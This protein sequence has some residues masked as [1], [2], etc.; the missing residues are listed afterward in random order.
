MFNYD[1]S[2]LTKN[3]APL[4]NKE[5]FLCFYGIFE[6]EK[7]PFLSFLLFKY[8]S[9]DLMSFIKIKLSDNIE[10]S[11]N[12]FSLRTMSIECNI[13]GYK[14]YDTHHYVFCFLD[15]PYMLQNEHSKK[16]QLWWATIDEICNQHRVLTFDI[17]HSV[18]GI[19]FQ[20][21]SLIYLLDEDKK[22]LV[23]PRIGYYGCNY[24]LM[25]YVSALGIQQSEYTPFGNFYYFNSYTRAFKY[26]GWDYNPGKY[27]NVDEHNRV[28]EGGIVRF[29]VFLKNNRMF[30]NHPQDPKHS[31]N[32]NK[33]EQ[34]EEI[35]KKYPRL[36]DVNGEWA[37]LNDSL[38]VGVMVDKNYKERFHKFVREQYIL[39]KFNDYVALSSHK[40]DKK[41]LG[42]EWKENG[43]YD[44]K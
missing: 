7:N 34:Y 8:P 42:I 9:T 31:F 43:E 27:I 28:E 22:P 37:K 5:V 2:T 24:K 4:K 21:P 39:K 25:S 3:T 6:R 19:F 38:Y 26:A 17:H 36:I 12:E 15:F 20:N 33:S 40:I 41:T 23:I 16:S 1:L 44:I 35:Y 32:K 30:L 13:M 11:I 18:Y 29:A 14:T 10:K